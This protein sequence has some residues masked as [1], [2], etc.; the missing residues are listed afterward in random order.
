MQRTDLWFIGCI[1]LAITFGYS[2][3][4]I[5]SVNLSIKEAPL[6]VSNKKIPTVPTVHITGIRNGKLNAET[7]GGA[8]LAIKDEIILS[9]SSGSISVDASSILTNI[10]SVQVP[11]GMHFV[12]SSRGK[13][14]YSVTSAAGKNIVP[15]NRVYFATEQEAKNAG[16]K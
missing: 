2:V 15:K 4:R 3:G 10:V 7:F 5:V 8:R 11:D 14:Y 6:I 13:K 9:N 12:A 16:Y 1:T